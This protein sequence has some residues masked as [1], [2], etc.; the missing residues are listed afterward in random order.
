M[1][2]TRAPAPPI[3]PDLLATA[4]RRAPTRL[5]RW[6]L[7]LLILAPGLA[8]AERA[9]LIARQDRAWAAACATC[10]G[11]SGSPPAGGAPALNGRDAELTY[12]QLLAYKDGR[13]PQATVMP[14]LAKGYSD[15]ELRR[16]ATYFASHPAS[17]SMAP[18]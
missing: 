13:M 10:H 12:A 7:A 5:A 18:R 3:A 1:P 15:D 11:A 14:Q 2:R 4:S 17:N 9:G 16:I 8:S 6:A